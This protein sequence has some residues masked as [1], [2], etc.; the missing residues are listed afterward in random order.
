MLASSILL[1]PVTIISPII[2]VSAIAFFTSLSPPMQSDKK[3]SI[4]DK[5]FNL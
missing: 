1:F 5:Y 3:T 4:I 2:C